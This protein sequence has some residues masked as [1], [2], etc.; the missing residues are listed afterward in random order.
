MRIQLLD[1]LRRVGFPPGAFVDGPSDAV[2]LSVD[3]NMA[4]HDRVWA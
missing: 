4:A 3:V 2:S 1:R